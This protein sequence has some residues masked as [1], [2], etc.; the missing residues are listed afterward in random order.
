MN[1][2]KLKKLILNGFST[3]ISDM[4]KHVFTGFVERANRESKIAADKEL[5]KSVG[6]DNNLNEILL[7]T[8]YVKIYTVTGNDKFD[9]DYPYRLIYKNK[10]DN[11][12]WR[13]CPE[14]LD[15]LDRAMLVYLQ[16]RHIGENSD[17]INL[18]TKILNS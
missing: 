9:G 18:T 3:D 16:Y 4:E 10:Q 14:A 6:L 7:S 13:R 15:T 1:I 8:D 11:S 17:F 5:I 12:A 2:E